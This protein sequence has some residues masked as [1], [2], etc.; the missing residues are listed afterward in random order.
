MNKLQ[1]VCGTATPDDVRFANKLLQE[2]KESSDDGLFFKSGLLNWNKMEMLTITDA[3]II[4]WR[5]GS[6]PLGM[7]DKQTSLLW[8]PLVSTLCFPFH[9]LL[10]LA[11]YVWRTRHGKLVPLHRVCLQMFRVAT[12][13]TGISPKRLRWI[14]PYLFRHAPSCVLSGRL[15]RSRVRF[16]LCSLLL[17]LLLR[18][19]P[20][21]RVS[22][23]RGRARVRHHVCKDPWSIC[24]RGSMA[25]PS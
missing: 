20:D 9:S 5:R 18:L 10:G 4:L 3:S 22:C 14:S 24:G 15:L 11:R 1:S 21:L 7:E 6:T 8:L 19:C 2:A 17:A 16:H 13:P 12:I 23:C 25:H